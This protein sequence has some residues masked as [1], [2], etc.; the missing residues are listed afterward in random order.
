MRVWLALS[1]VLAALFV[2]TEVY[3][4]SS[5]FLV[6]LGVVGQSGVQNVTSVGINI[7][8]LSLP[9]TLD[10]QYSD[11]EGDPVSVGVLAGDLP[12]QSISIADHGDGT[13]TVTIGQGTEAGAYMFWIEATD[14]FNH[15][16]E[17]FVVQ[18][19]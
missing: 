8:A 4:Q 7:D 12:E 15:V 13:A 9:T 18:I 3:A 5:E 11:T 10:I 16:L 19:P 17:P 14:P 1:L 2:T 6:P